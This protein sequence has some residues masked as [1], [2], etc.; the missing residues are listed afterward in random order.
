MIVVSTDYYNY[1]KDTSPENAKL[2]GQLL[3]SSN[4][5]TQDEEISGLEKPATAPALGRLF[6]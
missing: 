3:P 4:E 1:L 2:F 5:Y 6:S